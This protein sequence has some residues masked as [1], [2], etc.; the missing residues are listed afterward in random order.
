MAEPCVRLKLEWPNFG[1][2]FGGEADCVG[3]GKKR[4]K[5]EP[6]LPNPWIG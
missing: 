6:S 2:P 4:V 3:G 1:T 5:L